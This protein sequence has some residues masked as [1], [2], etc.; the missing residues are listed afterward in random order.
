MV[1]DDISVQPGSTTLNSLEEEFV[2]FLEHYPI[3]NVSKDELKLRGLE[4][5]KRGLEGSD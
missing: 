4:Y 1:Q 5:L 3:G 2:S